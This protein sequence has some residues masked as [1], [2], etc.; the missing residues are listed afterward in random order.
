MKKRKMS[1]TYEEWRL[2]VYALNKLRNSLIAEG[3]HTDTV[4]DALIA[5]MNAK[6]KW[7]KVAG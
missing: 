2:I 1:F 7:V 5:A 6:T 4:D 3:R